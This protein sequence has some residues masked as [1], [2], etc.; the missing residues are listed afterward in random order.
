MGKPDSRAASSPVLGRVFPCKLA[1]HPEAGT[2]LPNP[3]ATCL[4]LAACSLYTVDHVFL[5]ENLPLVFFSV[6]IHFICFYFYFYCFFRAIPVAYESSQAR[7][8]IGAVADSLHTPQPQPHRI[9]A[10]SAICT[11]AHRNAGSLT[12]WGRPGIEPTSSWILVRFI[13]PLPRWELL[14]S[15]IFNVCP[16]DIT[17]HLR[18]CPWV[19]RGWRLLLFS[20]GFLIIS[21]Q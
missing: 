7:G 20:F 8:R 10:V 3:Q 2:R 12:H 4:A 11:T 19:F 9:W 18:I 17:Y 6:H 13:S 5:P 14:N 15:V 21:F 1:L 16:G